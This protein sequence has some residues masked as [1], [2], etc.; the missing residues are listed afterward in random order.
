MMAPRPNTPPGP[1]PMP[2]A[3]AP[4]P[5]KAAEYSPNGPTQVWRSN[6]TTRSEGQNGSPSINS[7]ENGGTNGSISGD[8]GFTTI[9]KRTD[10]NSTGSSN[11]GSESNGTSG[12]TS[13]K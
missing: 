1:A 6:E 9:P 13:G 12:N 8:S 7:S 10:D 11:S 5:G 4:A 2:P 3:P